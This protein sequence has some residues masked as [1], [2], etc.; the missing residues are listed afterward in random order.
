MT[1]III[2]VIRITI[3]I[4]IIVIRGNPKRKAKQNKARRADRT[5]PLN[6]AELDYQHCQYFSVLSVWHSVSSVVIS[7]VFSI[8]RIISIVAGGSAG[9]RAP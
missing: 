1:I 6:W 5:K 2:M 8:I 4:I 9:S 3:I 7:V